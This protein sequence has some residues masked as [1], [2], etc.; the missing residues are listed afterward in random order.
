MPRWKRSDAAP[1]RSLGWLG[2]AALGL[3]LMLSSCVTIIGGTVGSGTLKTE[4]RDVSGFT[5]VTF[6]GVGTLNI[7]ETGTES[8]TIS[9]D[10][11][12]LPLLTSTVNNNTLFLGVKPG[13]SINPVKPITYTLTV[14]QLNNVTLSG[15]GKINATNITTDAL[16]VTL[17]GAGSMTITGS[18]QSQQALVSGVGSYSAKGFPTDTAQVTISGAGSATI[19]VNKELTVIVSGA[20]SVTYYGSPSQ[21]T[22]TISGA[23]SVKQG[24]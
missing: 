14:K 12:L 1:R 16:N 22:K 4:T 21:V 8:L 18:A 17:S 13:N 15:A 10:D 3:A 20:G 2:L 11:N 24:S 6:S 19:T 9:A 5:G 23:G 7:T